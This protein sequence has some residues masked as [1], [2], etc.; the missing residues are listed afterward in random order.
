MSKNG[1]SSIKQHFTGLFPSG[2]AI[3]P[4]SFLPKSKKV[5]EKFGTVDILVNNAGFAVLIK[6]KR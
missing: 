2:L 3:T 1:K 5:L 6:K 4:F